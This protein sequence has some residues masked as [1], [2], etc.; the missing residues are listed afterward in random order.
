MVFMVPTPHYPPA[1][2]KK[3]GFLVTWVSVPLFHFACIIFF[4]LL[5]IYSSVYCLWKCKLNI[6]V[7]LVLM[8]SL[9]CAQGGWEND[10]TVEEA[11]VREALEEA[12]VRGDL[13]VRICCFQMLYWLSVW[14]LLNL[15]EIFYHI[16]QFM[17]NK[18]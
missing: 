8:N 17:N 1:K 9:L 6:E 4:L 5:C 7:T 2:P 12:G 13:M 11:A 18:K 3:E 15:L 16:T 14:S 10:E